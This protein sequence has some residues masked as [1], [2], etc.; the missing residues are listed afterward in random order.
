MMRDAIC[1]CSSERVRRW[2]DVA[3][4]LCMQ[5][6]GSSSKQRGMSKKGERGEG[7]FTP[8]YALVIPMGS[9]VCSTA[10]QRVCVDSYL[11][12][13]SHSIIHQQALRHLAAAARL[14]PC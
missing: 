2:Y 14:N 11:L 5:S 8:I 6:G 1:D 13:T 7:V 4:L 9:A 12:C 10:S 3:M